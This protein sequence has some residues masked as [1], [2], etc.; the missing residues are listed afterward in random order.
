MIAASIA[1]LSLAAPALAHAETDM[2]LYA[3][4]GGAVL[5]SDPLNLAVVQARVGARF[6]TYFG[7]EAEGALGGTVDSITSGGSTVRFRARSEIAGYAVGFVPVT[8]NTDVLVRIGYGTNT[9]HAKVVGVGSADIDLN[10]VNYG[11]GVQHMFD[12]NNGLRADYTRLEFQ[13]SGLESADVWSVAY[14]RKF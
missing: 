6:A 7:A 3:T 14:V 11:V 2:N 12:D 9:I 5:H 10:S 8:P 1:A 13:D 4:V